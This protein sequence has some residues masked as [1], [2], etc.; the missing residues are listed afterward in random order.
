MARLSGP[1]S[2]VILYDAAEEIR[3]G[4]ARQL[5]DAGPP[6]AVHA[7][8]RMPLRLLRRARP[9]SCPYRAG[10]QSIAGDL[11]SDRIGIRIYRRC[12]HRAIQSPRRAACLSIGD[13]STKVCGGSLSAFG[14]FFKKSW[15]TNDI[16]AERLDASC[17]LL[18]CLLTKE[19]LAD[20]PA[21]RMYNPRV[22]DQMLRGTFTRRAPLL[23]QTLSITIC[24]I[25][26]ATEDTWNRLLY[27]IV[28]ASHDEIQLEEWPRVICCAPDREYK[29]G[30]YKRHTNPRAGPFDIPN[31][32]WNRSKKNPDSGHG[33]K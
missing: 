25:R 4:R 26:A 30:R 8:R 21:G 15:R 28:A 24:E 3:L 27:E 2:A 5:L 1:F 9:L 7:V 19:R 32:V 13:P 33:W 20:L 12:A 16:M 10:Y 23:W 14:G 6:E 22:V 29:W 11:N 18:E 31:L 17:Q